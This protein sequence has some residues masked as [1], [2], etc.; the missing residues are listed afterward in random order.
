MTVCIAALAENETSVV[1]AADRMVT[2]GFP[3]NLELEHDQPKIDAVSSRC[4][5]LSSGD[6]L[7]AA[8]LLDAPDLAP[9]LES[10]RDFVTVA[11]VLIE[12]Y[13][14]L[15]NQR[16]EQALLSPLKLTWD[17]FKK[18]GATTLPMP[19]YQTLFQNLNGFGIDLELLV[20]GRDDQGCHIAHVHPPAPR[21]FCDFLNRIGYHAIGSGG[22]HATITLS[23]L[24][25]SVAASIEQTLFNVFV[26]KKAAEVAPGVGSATDILVLNNAGVWKADDNVFETLK[27]A[28]NEREQQ[29]VRVNL[30]EIKEMFNAI[31]SADVG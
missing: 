19:A 11:G 8:E 24:K 17:E 13:S 29:T 10:K 14:T 21:G 12:R 30:G 3:L 25:H 5:A 9:L 4:L 1:V 15:R 31:V 6:A 16:A 7:M 20:V 23:L 26:A 27:R 2:A 22:I 18:S 28:Q